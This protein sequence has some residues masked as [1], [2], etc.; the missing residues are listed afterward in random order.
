M[1]KKSNQSAADRTCA[2]Y[3]EVLLPQDNHAPAIVEPSGLEVKRIDLMGDGKNYLTPAWHY[4]PL[5]G[6]KGKTL[7]GKEIKKYKR[8]EAG[9]L[10]QCASCRVEASIKR[11]VVV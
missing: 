3:P 8:C 2:I 5:T 7:C 4:Y 11:A 6:D 9:S 10:G 1:A